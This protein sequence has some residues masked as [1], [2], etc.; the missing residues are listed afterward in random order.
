MIVRTC[1]ITLLILVTSV[2]VVVPVGSALA[3]AWSHPV[4]LSNPSLAGALPRGLATDGAGRAYVIL[5]Q[6]TGFNHDQR[7]EEAVLSASG[8][9][10][11]TNQLSI[12]GQRAED[13]QVAVNASGNA[14]FAW[15]RVPDPH[16]VAT[17]KVQLRRRGT[18]GKLG[19]VTD[20]SDI[21]HNA[22]LDGIGIG[23]SGDGLVL[24]KNDDTGAIEL[25]GITSTGV[26]GPIETVAQPDPA[27][28]ELM[29]PAMHEFPDGS[30]AVSWVRNTDKSDSHIVVQARFR[31]AG[32]QWSAL[33]TVSN[34]AL[35]ARPGIFTP[36]L[37]G[38]TADDGL[39]TWPSWNGTVDRVQTR[40][41]T[42]DGVSGAVTLGNDKIE[43]VPTSAYLQDDGTALVG[44]EQG[45]FRDSR[46]QAQWLFAD[47]SRSSVV[48]LA[49]VGVE[50]LPTRVVPEGDNTAWAVFG[51]PLQG[52]IQARTV[53]TSG[54]VGPRE[55]V[56][57]PPL[58]PNG[59][60]DT[61]F[62]A[63]GPNGE[64]VVAFDYTHDHEQEV[65]ATVRRAM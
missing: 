5:E 7:Q 34:P 13:G 23:S 33:R 2:M 44:W 47:G 35:P 10:L 22:E 37:A 20:V 32:G 28:G 49:P 62:A 53:Q 51:G 60:I 46:A 38:N 3:S 40:R 65:G 59:V 12:A 1:R 55:V 50:E 48:N 61:L 64:L 8:K 6:T 24:M 9:L 41:I 25:R 4:T 17:T 14:L 39:I 21:S 42:W 36:I 31:R 16:T 56:P 58:D 54:A 29:A 30:A 63:S 11:E 57:T 18:S 26:L 19:R 15:T 43:A 45:G 27:G 52:E